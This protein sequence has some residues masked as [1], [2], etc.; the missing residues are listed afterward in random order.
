MIL[1]QL[2]L[3]LSGK[4]GKAVAVFTIVQQ[5][6]ESR[7]IIEFFEQLKIICSVLYFQCRNKSCSPLLTAARDRLLAKNLQYRLMNIFSLMLAYNGM[8]KYIFFENTSEKV[9]ELPD[10]SLPGLHL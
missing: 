1:P 9:K 3:Y 2:K 8:I 4:H 7:K 5:E 10:R 6:P